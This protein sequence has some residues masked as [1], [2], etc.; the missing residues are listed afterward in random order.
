MEG[1]RNADQL[2]RKESKK[3]SSGERKDS[4]CGKEWEW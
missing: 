2:N 4:D 3:V 1:N